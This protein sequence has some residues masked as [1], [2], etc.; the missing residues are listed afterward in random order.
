MKMKELSKIFALL[1]GL[2]G[3]LYGILDV[4][5]LGGTIPGWGLSIIP[6]AIISGILLIVLSLIVLATSGWIKISALKLNF[7]LL[8]LLILGVLM[9]LTSGGLAGILVIVAAILLLL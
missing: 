9:L 5:T 2:L 3:L 7:N 4:L 6:D 1:G 8:I